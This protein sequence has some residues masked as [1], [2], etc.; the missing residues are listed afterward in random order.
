MSDVRD[1]IE[2]RVHE[3]PGIYFNDR[4]ERFLTDYQNQYDRLP[5]Y[6]GGTAYEAIHVWAEA[7]NE[8]GTVNEDDVIKQLESQSVESVF[9]NIGFYPEGDDQVHD[10]IYKKG[11]TWDLMLQWQQGGSDDDIWAGNGKQACVFYDD[12]V[13]AEFQTPDYA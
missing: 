3:D 4:T 13:N 8:V 5:T 10:L 2:R 9:G 11:E 12:Y 1:R 6:T 7:A